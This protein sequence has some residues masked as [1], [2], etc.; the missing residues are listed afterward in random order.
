MTVEV[1]VLRMDDCLEDGGWRIYG[2][3]K[4]GLMKDG[5]SKAA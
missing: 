5:G 1:A 4:D 3:M 2:W